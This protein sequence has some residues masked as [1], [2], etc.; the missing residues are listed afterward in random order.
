MFRSCF[1]AALVLGLAGPCLAQTEDEV[2]AAR[3]LYID[4]DY[5]T[6]LEVLR[7][8]AEAGIQAGRSRSQP[9]TRGWAPGRRRRV[10]VRCG[11]EEA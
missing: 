4:G 5:A 8:A 7:P 9:A 1:A 10:I 11:V 6:A 3:L 2:A